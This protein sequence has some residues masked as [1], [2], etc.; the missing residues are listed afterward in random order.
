M[1]KELTFNAVCRRIATVICL[2]AVFRVLFTCVYVAWG[3]T[4]AVF[5]CDLS[6]CAMLG[7]YFKLV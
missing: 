3:S 7:L 2:S 4:A 6:A 5:F 1:V